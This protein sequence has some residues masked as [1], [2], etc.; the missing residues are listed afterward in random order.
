CWVRFRTDNFR[1]TEE[2]R[3]S[4]VVV[5]IDAL[6]Q[7]P[8]GATGYRGRMPLPKLHLTAAPFD[9]ALRGCF[10]AGSF[11]AGS[12]R[13]CVVSDTGEER[14]HSEGVHLFSWVEG[15]RDSRGVVIAERRGMRTAKR[16]SVVGSV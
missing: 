14:W 13:A 4:P 7:P 9:V 10:G 5:L 16:E 6:S 1:S 3:I 12:L 15:G 11:D 2:R 8:R